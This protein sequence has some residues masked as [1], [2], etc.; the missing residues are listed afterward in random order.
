MR[1]KKIIKKLLSKNLPIT[2]YGIND[3][4]DFDLLKEKKAN[5]V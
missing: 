3:K 5:K 4:I 2:I 1:N